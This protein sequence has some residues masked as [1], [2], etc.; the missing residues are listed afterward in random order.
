M[1]AARRPSRVRPRPGAGR[2]D[3]GRRRPGGGAAVHRARGRRRG[4]RRRRRAARPRL[5][6]RGRRRGRAGRRRHRGRAQRDPA[7]R[8]ARARAGRAAVHPEAKLGIGP[9]ITDGFYYDF[10]VARAV[11]AG[12]PGQTLER[13]CSKIIKSGQR[14]SRRRYD[15]VDEARKRAG[16]RAVQAGA[17]RPQGRTPR[18]P[19]SREVGGRRLRRAHRVRQPARAHRRASS[20]ATCAAARTCRPPATSRRS[21]SCAA[22]A[23]YWRG[24]EKN[25]QLQRDLRHGVGVARRRWTRTC[26]GSP[27]PSGATTAGSAPSWT[28]SRF[29]DEIGSGLAVFHPKGGIIRKELEDYSRRRHERGGLRVRQHPAHHQGAAVRDLRAPR[30]VRRGHVPAHAARRR[31]ER[32]RHGPQAGAG[33]LPQADELPDA[34]P[35]LPVARPSLPGAAAAA[36]RVRHRLPL[37]EVGRGARADPG[38]RVHPGRRAHLLHPR[39]D[40]G[41]DA[42][43][44][45]SSCWTCCATTASTTSTWSCPPATRTSTI[46]SDEDWELATDALREAARR[47]A[48][49]WCP[50]RAAPRSTGRRSR[51]QARDAIGRTWQMSTIQVDFMQ[52]DRFDLE[53]TAADGSRQQPVM[54][55]RALFGSIERFFGVLTEHYAG[56]FPAWLAPVQAVAHPGRRTSRCARRGR[57]RRAAGA[58]HPGRGRR[59][60]RPDAEEDPH[61]HRWRRCRSCCWPARRTPRRAR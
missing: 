47:R 45:C 61:P 6:A 26:T 7:L 34:Q 13:R 53:Y 55:H 38:A 8:R 41:R 12:G 23:A 20:G 18:R 5:G 22:A 46:G 42:G 49:S 39:A 27:R 24:N 57:R 9:P 15:S 33:L 17:D 31:A 59:L 32:G 35:D 56:A 37:R 52:P 48:W 43:R 40:A 50:T 10:D 1:S 21:S 29:P 3:G 16:G 44:C 28:C 14:F 58:G 60:R 51:V 36:V 19:T 4:P 25:P 30:L 54:I 11:H 2:D